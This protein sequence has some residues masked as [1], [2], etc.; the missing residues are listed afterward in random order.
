MAVELFEEWSSKLAWPWDSEKIWS[1]CHNA[2]RYGQNERGAKSHEVSLAGYQAHLDALPADEQ[3]AEEQPAEDDG[4]PV[5]V[6]GS[7]QFDNHHVKALWEVDDDTI[8]EQMTAPAL[9]PKWIERGVVNYL[10][11]GPNLGKSLIALQ[12]AACL[13]AGCDILGEPVEQ[14][15]CYIL[16]YEEPRDE[17]KRRLYRIRQALGGVHSFDSVGPDGR[18]TITQGAPLATG[19]RIHARHLKDEPAHLLRVDKDGKIILTRFGRAFLAEMKAA[20]GHKFV[21][22]DG[23]IDAILFEGGTRNDDGIARQLIALLDRWCTEYD[24][25]AYA[26]LHP[27]RIAERQGGGSYAPAWDTK[28]RCIDTFVAVGLDGHTIPPSKLEE[29]PANQILLAVLQ[30]SAATARE[31][32]TAICTMSRAPLCQCGRAAARMPFS[33]RSIWHARARR[34]TGCG[35]NATAPAAPKRR[36]SPARMP[37]FGSTSAAPRTLRPG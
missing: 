7:K 20:P 26:I 32:T 19:G 5:T 11:G 23:I 36:S 33:L 4:G 25:S 35:S 14:T 34:L 10:S 29:T 1:L 21:V 6:G 13:A 3:P 16:N 27:S 9:A 31:A 24:F 28:P 17:Y 2:G 30:R 18:E 8:P 22:F 15:P 37:P 12:D